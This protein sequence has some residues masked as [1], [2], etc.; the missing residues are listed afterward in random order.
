MSEHITLP[1]ELLPSDGRFGSGPALVR[2]ESVQRLAA[3]A[4]HYLGTS[5]RRDGVRR[6]VGDI[7]G[8]LRSLYALPDDYEVVLGVGGA[9]MFWEVAARSLIRRRSQHVSIGEFS[10]KFAAVAASIRYLDL[11]V[12]ITAPPG[13][14]ADPVPDPSVDAFCLIHNET[15][16]GVMAPLQRPQTGALV[17]VDG[18][19]AAGAVRVDPALFDAYYFSP[20]KAF[21]SEGG[22]WA[23]LCSAAAIERAEELAA[24]RKLTPMT[25][26][27]IAVENSRLDQTYNT[28]ALATLFLLADQI[29]WI[30]AQGGLAWAESR[31]RASSTIVYEWAEAT[32][33]TTPFV[34]DP[35]LRSP[36]VATVDLDD[37]VSA[38]AIADV[39][40]AHGVVDILGYRKI[41]Q[42]Q[43]RIAT[44]PN[45]EP[46]DVERLLAAVDYI[47]EHQGHDPRAVR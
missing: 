39:L 18:T 36:T 27:Q 8:G 43:L 40:A 23:A 20:Q 7:R 46:R 33:Y 6:V 5:H 29:A 2:Q 22:L 28:P 11:P 26:L 15:S 47:V 14:A 31:S 41:A 42:N 3:V 24:E 44:F 45:V 21:G 30:D 32:D 19:S 1:P 25:S 12:V 17:L 9:T 16:T 10:S 35:Q 37:A 4:N 38:Q 13:S 34:H